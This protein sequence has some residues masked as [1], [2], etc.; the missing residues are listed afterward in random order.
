MPAYTE[1]EQR[2]ACSRRSALN[3]AR[4]SKSTASVATDLA[5]G[6]QVNRDGSCAIRPRQAKVGTGRSY[7]VPNRAIFTTV[8]DM[9]RFVAFELG[10]GPATVLPAAR[11]E[12]AFGEVRRILGRSIR[13][14]QQVSWRC[15]A[16]SS[17]TPG[18]AA[19]SQAASASMY[20]DRNARSS[21]SS[22][23]FRN[24]AGGK[25]NPDRLAV[26]I[27]ERLVNARRA[28]WAATTARRIKDQTPAPGSEA[29]MRRIVEEL[30]AGNPNYDLY[31][32]GLAQ[33]TRQQLP[34]LQSTVV[35]P[36]CAAVG[37]VQ[38]CRCR[39]RVRCLSAPS[40]RKRSLEWR[41]WLSADG[42][43]LLSAG[44]RPVMA[45]P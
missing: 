42:S 31:A 34:Q 21:A 12:S 19:P 13:G 32:P 39:S 3:A 25:E 16:T 20:F 33:V 11:L 22:A 41:I 44:A 29:T 18:T 15:A 6:Y 35:A 28:D 2:R 14:I 9:S 24:V 7:K 10:N 43:K 8:D 40:S 1:W 38:G 23:L 45:S 5:T 36:R 4:S 37:H 26:D 17:R 27:L 30:R